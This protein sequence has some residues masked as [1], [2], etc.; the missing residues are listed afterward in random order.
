MDEVLTR[1]GQCTQRFGLIRVWFQNSEAVI[2]SPGELAEHERVEAIGLASRDT[3]PVPGSCDLVRMQRQHLHAGVEEPL[4]QHA[5]WPLDRDQVNLHL[6]QRPAQR[7]QPG[8][9]VGKR[10]RQQLLAGLVGDAH[11]VL[12]SR[13]VKRQGPQP[14]L[15]PVA[16]CGTSPPLGRAGLWQ[17]LRKGQG[18]EALFQR[19]SRL[20]QDVL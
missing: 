2:V 19:R 5:V 17:A 11:V 18:I 15:R 4:D 3:E 8:L 13:P 14:G 12:L 9:V 16:A 7:Q 20:N 10:R 6:H 1:P